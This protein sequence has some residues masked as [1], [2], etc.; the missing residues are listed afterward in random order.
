M[1]AHRDSHTGSRSESLA[2]SMALSGPVDWACANNAGRRGFTC[3]AAMVEGCI[4]QHRAAGGGRSKENQLGDLKRILGGRR[5]GAGQVDDQYAAEAVVSG[6][7][8]CL[9]FG[10]LM[11]RPMHP[12]P[13][14]AG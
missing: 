2:E 6:S 4:K 10:N 12:M 13:C 11:L 1:V 7:A 3:C 14:D 9:A 8:R 5:C